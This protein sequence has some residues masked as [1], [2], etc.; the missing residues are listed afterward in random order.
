MTFNEWVQGAQIVGAGGALIL[1]IVAWK[2]WAAYREEVTYSK[3][4][5]KETLSILNSLTGT[6]KDEQVSELRREDKLMNAIQELKT[7]ITNHISK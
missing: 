1:G 6:M 2:L 7:L 4:S 3:A 5:D